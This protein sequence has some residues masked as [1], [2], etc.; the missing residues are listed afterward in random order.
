[1]RMILDIDEVIVARA[2]AE[3]T[4]TD[5]IALAVRAY[6]FNAGPGMQVESAVDVQDRRE[7]L[8]AA[9][10][11]LIDDQR[12]LDGF[13]ARTGFALEQVY[14]ARRKLL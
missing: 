9:L 14:A 1:M 11:G 7:L 8:I 3:M 5:A 13:I 10:D 2:T 4:G 6:G 12:A